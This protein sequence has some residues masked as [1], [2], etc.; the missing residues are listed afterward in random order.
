VRV[1]LSPKELVLIYTRKEWEQLE[2]VY[3]KA[4]LEDYVTQHFLGRYTMRV[5]RYRDSYQ[6]VFPT[7]SFNITINSQTYTIDIVDDINERF[8]VK[9]NGYNVYVVNLSIFRVIPQCGEKEC[10]AVI[11]IDDSAMMV[12]PYP[13][14]TLIVMLHAFKLAL[15]TVLQKNVKVKYHLVASIEFP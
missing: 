2:K 11:P 4:G 5:Y 6:R 13:A 10:R 9:P 8:I 14:I 7:T 1:E 3:R 12:A 15:A